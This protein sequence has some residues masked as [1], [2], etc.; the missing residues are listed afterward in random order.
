MVI[1]D[2]SFSPCLDLF[3]MEVKYVDGEL[4]DFLDANNDIMFVLAH[5]IISFCV[6]NYSNRAINIGCKIPVDL[7]V[8]VG[9][10]KKSE[11]FTAIDCNMRNFIINIMGIQTVII[12]QKRNEEKF[13]RCAD[14]NNNVS[15]I[16]NKKGT[17]AGFQIDSFGTVNIGG[18]IGSVML[19]SYN[20]NHYDAIIV[21]HEGV[22]KLGMFQ[23]VDNPVEQLRVFSANDEEDIQNSRASSSYQLTNEYK[24]ETVTEAETESDL[25]A[26]AIFASL[27][28]LNSVISIGSI[29]SVG[30]V[31]SVGSAGLTG[32]ASSIS[33]ATSN[34]I[35]DTSMDEIIARTLVGE[36]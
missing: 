16:F 6:K 11:R 1:V 20:A 35:P 28:P 30:S 15:Q 32:S 24:S 31:G 34:Q 21:N 8:C 22:D 27:N 4:S 29:G 10:N 7:E 26:A 9:F 36:R 17:Y 14:P 5:N 13:R 18:Y 19:Y 25:L 23:S 12:Y 33:L 3:L 2:E